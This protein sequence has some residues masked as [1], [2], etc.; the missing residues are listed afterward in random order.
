MIDLE[1]VKHCIENRISF[2]ASNTFGHDVPMVAC[3]SGAGFYLGYIDMTGPVS[4]DS[5]EYYGT[6]EEAEQALKDR[7]WTQ[8]THP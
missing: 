1:R 4:R 8:R 3:Q 5:Q 7:S 2:L 6:K